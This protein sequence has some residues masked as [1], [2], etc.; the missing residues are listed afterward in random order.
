MK[1]SHEAHM[2]FALDLMN[3][4]NV[5]TVRDINLL[6]QPFAKLF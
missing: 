3:S 1:K 4:K 6:T 5:E 2:Y